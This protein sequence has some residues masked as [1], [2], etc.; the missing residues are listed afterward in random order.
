M[1]DT[2]RSVWIM[3]FIDEDN[4]KIIVSWDVVSVTSLQPCVLYIV[5]YNLI[6]LLLF[7]IFW[8]KMLKYG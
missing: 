4:F 2:K 7:C 3:L 8:K 6:L 5:L 1:H